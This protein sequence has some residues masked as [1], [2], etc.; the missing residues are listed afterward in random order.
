MAMDPVCRMN[1][2]PERAA[3]EVRYQGEV[4][5]FCSIPCKDAFL[6]NP[7]MYLERPIAEHPPGYTPRK[8]NE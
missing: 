6:A 4:F 1:V 7:R 2:V 5:Y 3:A 8:P